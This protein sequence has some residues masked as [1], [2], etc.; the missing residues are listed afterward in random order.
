MAKQPRNPDCGRCNGIEY[1]HIIDRVTSLN[2]EARNVGPPAW[3]EV[4]T[5]V[6]YLDF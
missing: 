2:V 6:T 1:I 5:L 3:P 4:N